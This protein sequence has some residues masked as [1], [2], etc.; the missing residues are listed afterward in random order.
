MPLARAAAS[1]KQPAVVR[2]QAVMPS[3]AAPREVRLAGS[4]FLAPG[5]IGLTRRSVAPVASRSS[6]MVVKAEAA[7]AAAV[8]AAE[9][10]KK[11][12]TQTLKVSLY[13]FGW[14]FLN[15]IFGEFHLVCSYRWS[16][17][18]GRRSS[19]ALGNRPP[20]PRS[21]AT[22]APTRSVTDPSDE[23]SYSLL[24]TM[25]FPP[26]PRNRTAIMNKKTL[27]V[28]PYPWILSWIQI[29][30]GAVF[31]LI[32]WK[33][34]I[35]K[36]P[37][38]GFTKDM[39]KALIPTSFYHMVAH[40]SACASYKF[41]SVSFM[42]VVKAG[43]PAIAVLLLSMF[44]GRKYSWRVWLTLIPIVGGVAVGSTTEINFSMAAFLCAMTSN[45][46]SAL[47]AATSKDL[48]ADTGLKG[49]NL[50]GGIAIVSGIMLLPLS[51]LVE[52]SQMGA[53]FAAAPALMTAKGTLLFG[54]WNAGFM[55]YLI[56]GSMFYHLYNQTAY[57]ALGELTP[58]SH[59][60]ANTVKRVVIILASVAVFKNPIT[61]LGQVSAAV[62][63]LGT[64]VYSVVV[65]QDK[66]KAAKAAAA[67]KAD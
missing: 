22:L 30:V 39:F 53:A 50:Y 37:E 41:G 64:F 5:A 1:A 33:L 63:I 58:L 47:R 44:F 31:M 55:A 43:E 40:V 24:L 16:R 32:M 57:Q 3:T 60:V 38:G 51:L 10:A 65:Q 56:I 54:I 14:Y 28:F 11:D 19:Q 29:A 21:R 67:A 17:I 25:I 52:G 66:E 4:A 61:P 8:E 45:V 20:R 27:A 2:A 23:K 35:F 59:S 62:A 36:P 13:I 7:S 6:R 42:Q 12:M 15:A 48:Q 18:V 26:H 34:R 46:T 9:P 49:I